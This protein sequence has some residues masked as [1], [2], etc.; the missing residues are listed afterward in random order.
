MA[1]EYPALW[2]R[3]TWM[4]ALPTDTGAV[5]YVDLRTGDSIPTDVHSPRLGPQIVTP[6]PA[7]FPGMRQAEIESPATSGFPGR[8]AELRGV[9]SAGRAGYDRVDTARTPGSTPANVPEVADSVRRGQL[10]GASNVPAAPGG[11]PRR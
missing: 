1:Q 9:D 11:R 8:G 3:T 7:P 2:G 5:G 4:T 10:R 6:R